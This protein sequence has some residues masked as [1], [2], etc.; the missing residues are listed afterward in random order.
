MPSLRLRHRIPCHGRHPEAATRQASQTSLPGKRQPC[1]R[2]IALSQHNGRDSALLLR[3]FPARLALRQAQLQ[4]RHP[5]THHAAVLHHQGP[6]TPL[7]AWAKQQRKKGITNTHNRARS[8]SYRNAA[9]AKAIAQLPSS[10]GK[11]RLQ[12]ICLLVG[13][14]RPVVAGG[15]KVVGGV[16]LVEVDC[17]CGWKALWTVLSSMLLVVLDRGGRLCRLQG[18]RVSWGVAGGVWLCMWVGGVALGCGLACFWAR[19]E[20]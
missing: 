5:G 14:P 2:R 12:P 11:L 20:L 13:R 4:H 1:R 15:R 6:G 16:F 7:E 9:L 19:Y 18:Y 17:R 10:M 3:S 8:I